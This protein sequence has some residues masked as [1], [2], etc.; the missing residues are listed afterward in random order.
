MLIP[1][2]DCCFILEKYGKLPKGILHIG[3]HECEELVDYE[4]CGIYAQNVYWVDA[5]EEKILEMKKKDIPNVYCAALDIEEKIVKFNITNNGQSSSLLELGTHK[6]SYPHIYVSEV[7][8]V[9]TQTGREFIEKNKIP[10]KECNFWNLDIQGKELD[11]LKSMGEYINFA[12]AIY[13]EV[14]TQEVYKGGCLL[15]DLDIFLQSKGFIR[16]NISMT[17][18]GWGDALYV[19]E[20]EV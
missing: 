13:S 12:D 19:R 3:A 1:F 14:N 6:N 17:G 11:V 5:I 18:A 7:R 8:T 20:R 2:I 4:K 10:I 15:R 16:V 9:K